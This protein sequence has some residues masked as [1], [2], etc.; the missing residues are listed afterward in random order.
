ME[1]LK[2]MDS[3]LVVGTVVD[4]YIIKVDYDTSANKRVKC[5]IHD[6]YKC[7]WRVRDA[8]RHDKPFK[9]A[10]HGLESCLPFVAWTNSYLVVPTLKF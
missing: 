2:E 3:M 4:E 10:F 1:D 5:L 9:E 8:E 7:T 6:L